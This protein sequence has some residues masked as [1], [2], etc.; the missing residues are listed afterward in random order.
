[1]SHSRGS[2]R[3]ASGSELAPST[4]NPVS[5]HGHIVLDFR[6]D[7]DVQFSDMLP[8]SWLE[9]PQFR[10][11]RVAKTCPLFVPGCNCALGMPAI[12]GSLGVPPVE[13]VQQAETPLFLRRRRGYPQLSNAAPDERFYIPS[14][15]PE[16]S[17]GPFIPSLGEFSLEGEE[18]TDLADE[19]PN[20]LGEEVNLQGEGAELYTEGLDSVTD[21][22][23]SDAEEL[24]FDGEELE[25]GS[26]PS[27]LS[28]D[29]T[30]IVRPSA[31][32][33]RDTHQEEQ[34]A[35]EE[36]KDTK[37]KVKRPPAS[38]PCMRPDTWQNMIECEGKKHPGEDGW[39]H[40]ECSGV[41]E[42]PPEEG[43]ITHPSLDY[44][45]ILT[46]I[47]RPLV[48]LRLHRGSRPH[49]CLAPS[50]ARRQET[51]RCDLTTTTRTTC[52]TGQET[53]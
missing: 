7:S 6:A 40:L 27:N 49:R 28:V 35:E 51:S 22:H 42:V 29:E 21:Q 23:E 30:T 39:Y 41:E 9:S 11:E 20:L 14:S 32:G 26:G 5:Q 3:Q 15:A 33:G 2:G 4:Y 46:T 34:T 31:S 18:E 25:S 50:R 48:L 36:T 45:R 44:R 13:Y 10:L 1:M 12:G 52:W 19:E 38:C 43:R 24:E 17:P 53:S 8:Y 16:L 37:K 47:D